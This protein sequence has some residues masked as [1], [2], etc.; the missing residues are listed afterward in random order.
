MSLGTQVH[1]THH[2]KDRFVSSGSLG[3]K[4]YKKAL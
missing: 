2:I 3:F 4:K 1:I